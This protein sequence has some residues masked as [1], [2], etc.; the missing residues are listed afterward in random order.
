MNNIYC[1][2]I[3]SKTG[4]PLD[5][6]IW[7]G[8]DGQPFGSAVAMNAIIFGDTYNIIDVEGGLAVQGNFHS[9]RGVSIGFGRGAKLVGT[10]Y[11]PDDI[12]FLINGNLSSQGPFVVVGHVVANGNVNVARGSTYLIGK[13]GDPN[14][15]NELKA[16]YHAPGGNRY[17][18]PSDKGNHYLIPNYDVSRYIPAQRIDGNLPAFFRD[19]R[20]GIEYYKQCI[21]NIPSNGQV[22]D[23]GHEWILQGNNPRQNVFTIDALPNGT[24]NKAIK[25]N[26]P[27]ESLIIVKVKSGPRAHLQFGIWGEEKYTNRTLFVFEDASNIFME[28]P[29]AIW[30]SIIAP[31]AI[32]HGHPTGGHISGNVAFRSLV[33]DAKSGFEIHWYPFVGGV[34]CESIEST[35]V[36][37]PTPIPVPRPTPIPAP[38]AQPCPEMMPCP[39]CPQ[40]M[41]CPEII[42]FPGCPD[43]PSCPPCEKQRTCPPCPKEKPCPPCPK[44]PISPIKPGLI[45]GSVSGCRCSRSHNWEVSLYEIKNNVRIQIF[46]ETLCCDEAFEICVP[47][48]GN[49]LLVICLPRNFR[50]SSRCKPSVIF[51]NIGVAHIMIDY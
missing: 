15:S 45:Q 22:L 1:N 48:D 3:M 49:Y 7:S 24:I 23:N 13:S 25:I 28:V 41:P 18:A 34:L 35:P 37:L 19:A 31:Q 20:A 26:V 11:S 51:K 14:Q 39:D 44:A 32:Y 5:N 40:I 29:A 38:V 47:Y 9:P 2:Q 33:V 8:I 12:R 42:P 6:I 10:G 43:I 4:I 50:R 36:P 30:G 27:D 21:Q 16:L 46:C 17:W